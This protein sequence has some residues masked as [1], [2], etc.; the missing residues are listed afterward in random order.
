MDTSGTAVVLVV[1]RSLGVLP[2]GFTGV[3]CA[4]RADGVHASNLISDETKESKTDSAAV[5][6][7]DVATTAELET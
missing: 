4:G 5:G 6:I 3:V 7:V 1:S 2:T